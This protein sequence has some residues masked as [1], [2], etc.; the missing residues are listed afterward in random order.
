M[1][2]PAGA[3]PLFHGGNAWSPVWNSRAECSSRDTI[4]AAETVAAQGT[5]STDLADV[6]IV[7]TII[8]EHPDAASDPVLF[9]AREAGVLR[10]EL[11]HL[12]RQESPTI[13]AG[14]LHRYR[15][16]GRELGEAA[17]S[18]ALRSHG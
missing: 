4:H 18:R 1:K 8:A 7:D 14:R 3:S 17:G 9:C 12:T 10:R 5:N 6:R 13:L 15:D 2:L 16:L 11:R